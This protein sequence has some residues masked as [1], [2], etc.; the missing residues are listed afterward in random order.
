MWILDG[1]SL[2]NFIFTSQDVNG[3]NILHEILLF[4]NCCVEEALQAWSEIIM[5]WK[6]TT[7]HFSMETHLI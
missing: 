1:N 5:K 7:K 2:E 3:E 6:Y 4:L